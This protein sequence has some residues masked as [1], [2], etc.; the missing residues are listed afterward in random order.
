MVRLTPDGSAL[1]CAVGSE[2][3]VYDHIFRP[4]TLSGASYC[5]HTSATEGFVI[6]SPNTQEPV[7]DLASYAE[8]GHCTPAEYL[9][10]AQ[11]PNPEITWTSPDDRELIGYLPYPGPGWTLYRPGHVTPLHVAAGINPHYVAW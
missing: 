5:S 10:L 9:T 2:S 4:S 3:N 11:H 1:A 8:K 6:V 7:A